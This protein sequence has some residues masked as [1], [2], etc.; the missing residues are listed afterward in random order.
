M[1]V[2]GI[3]PRFDQP[4]QYSSKWAHDVLDKYELIDLS[5]D[6][7]TRQ[8][9]EKAIKEHDPKCIIFY[10]H[11]SETVLWAQG[12][13][14]GVFD[15]ENAHLT[16][17]RSVYTLACLSGKELLPKM[18]EEGALATFGY[19]RIYGFYIGAYE[20]YFEEQANCGLEALLEGRT[21]GEARERF[22]DRCQQM[23]EELDRLGV[24]HVADQL[25]WNMESLKVLGDLTT[26]IPIPPRKKPTC[27]V[28]YVIA[29][30]FG[31]QTLDLLRE[32]RRKLKMG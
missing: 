14:E 17:T 23:V 26:K 24:P 9:A 21:Y 4:T 3:V 16:K 28:S 30:L 2:L 20:K 32:I 18:V 19:D 12:G 27:P 15:M 1:S 22:Q 6:R 29:T 11:G 10:D 5:G 7:A 25:V 8:E 31:Y 13:Q